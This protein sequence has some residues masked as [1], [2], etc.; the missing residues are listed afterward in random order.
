MYENLE[1]LCRGFEFKKKVTSSKG[2]GVAFRK[3]YGF[4]MKKFGI[5]PDSVA[6][7]NPILLFEALDEDERQEEVILSEHLKMFYGQ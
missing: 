3:L 5:M 2:D 1:F 7:Q 6:R 4:F